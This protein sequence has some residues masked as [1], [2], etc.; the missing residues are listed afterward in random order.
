VIARDRVIEK[1]WDE[2]LGLNVTE[3]GYAIIPSTLSPEDV[4]R[5]V[6]ALQN[7]SGHRGRA[8]A[9]H[10]LSSPAVAELANAPQLLRI[11]KAILGDDAFAFRATLFDK[12][13]EANWLI[14][15][16]QDTALPLREK[17][18]TPGWG[19]WS[20]KA[21]ITYAHA[22]ATSLEQVVALRIHLDDS[23]P[24][25]GP[26][27]V[28]RGTHRDGVFTDQRIEEIVAKANPVT[29]LVSKG[30]VI[31]MRPL[32]IHASSKSDSE[33]PRRVLHLEYATPHSVEPPLQLAIA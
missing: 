6:P 8:G 5:F 14:A 1:L 13:A 24:E 27:R 31:V 3:D 32:I 22:P 26:L 16:H 17:L 23:T 20:V 4:E 9:R 7:L 29:C 12:N 28:L 25:N 33:T 2:T 10:L 30:G 19:P 15:W 21:G 11:A 18:D